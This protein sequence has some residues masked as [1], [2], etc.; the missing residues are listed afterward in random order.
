MPPVSPWQE[1]PQISAS[2][3]QHAQISLGSGTAM[4][5]NETSEV[6]ESVSSHGFISC[7]TP[8]LK[9]LA[10]TVFMSKYINKHIYIIHKSHINKSN[11]W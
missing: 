10:S 6:M 2:S 1:I 8:G 5:K 9:R 3:Y 4:T 7:L 11:T